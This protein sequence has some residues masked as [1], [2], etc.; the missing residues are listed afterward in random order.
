M[1]VILYIFIISIICLLLQIISS[2]IASRFF[3]KYYI[4]KKL[5]DLEYDLNRINLSIGLLS[6]KDKDKYMKKYTKIIREKY[7]Y[8]I[9]L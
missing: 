9:K 8:Y 5:I 1:I 6:D 3:T 2:Y 4:S 7:S